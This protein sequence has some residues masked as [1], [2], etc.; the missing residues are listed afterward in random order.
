M[1]C[2]CVEGVS[3]FLY[4][5]ARQVLYCLMLP[6]HIKSYPL[7]SQNHLRPD[8]VK[9]PMFDTDGISSAQDQY[10]LKAGMVSSTLASTSH[11]ASEGISA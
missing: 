3:F 5:T 9:V 11:A 10:L 1:R 7:S 8:L 2:E 4:V 6:R